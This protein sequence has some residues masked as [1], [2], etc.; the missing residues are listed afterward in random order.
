MRPLSQAYTAYHSKRV[1]RICTDCY[2]IQLQYLNLKYRLF[3]A[4]VYA[5]SNIGLLLLQAYIIIH[6]NITTLRKFTIHRPILGP[7]Y[8]IRQV[9]Y[10]VSRSTKTNARLSSLFRTVIIYIIFWCT[11]NDLKVYRKRTCGVPKLHSK[12]C[13]VPNWTCTELDLPRRHSRHKILDPLKCEAYRKAT[14]K[15]RVKQISSATVVNVSDLSP[16]PPLPPIVNLSSIVHLMKKNFLPFAEFLQ[17]LP[18]TITL[19]S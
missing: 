10:I 13:G 4:Y 14:N 16:V 7:N 9:L 8:F 1:L 15:M 12:I 18:I 2:N 19:C 11:E 5:D 3:I 17:F 6:N